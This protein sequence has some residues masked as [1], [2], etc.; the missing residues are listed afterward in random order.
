[1]L[2]DKWL[3]WRFKRGSS[4][5]LR[6]IYGKYERYLLTLAAALLIDIADA[7][8]AVHDVFV[9]FA[10]SRERIGLNGSLRGYLATCVFNRARDV[11]RAR[12]RGKGVSLDDVPEPAGEARDRPDL[13]AICDEESRVLH[14]ALAGIPYEQREVVVLHVYDGM[15]F[16]QIADLQ[17]ASINTVQGRYRYGLAKLRTLLGNEEHNEFEK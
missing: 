17:G 6:R 1:M 16:R 13:T 15:T 9:T 10:Q 12:H 14:R 5:A 7:E 4:D 8:D 2:E 3:I 11:I